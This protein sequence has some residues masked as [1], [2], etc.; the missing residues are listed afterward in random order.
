MGLI[1]F[2]WGVMQEKPMRALVWLFSV[3]AAVYG[4]AK[5]FVGA[6]VVKGQ[7]HSQNR[8]HLTL[9]GIDNGE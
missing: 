8:H 4:D 7:H 5:I 3:L 9:P 2:L 6:L 1:A